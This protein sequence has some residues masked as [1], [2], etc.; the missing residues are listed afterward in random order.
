[1]IRIQPSAGFTLI[2][3]LVAMAIFAIG[4]GLVVLG[5]GQLADRDMEGEAAKITAW[6][7]SLSDRAVLEG[8]I[9]GFRVVENQLQAVSWYDHQWLVVEHEG[10]LS[11]PANIHFELATD[12]P[13]KGFIAQVDSPQTMAAGASTGLTSSDANVLLPEDDLIE[14][15]MVFMPSGEPMSEGEIYLQRSSGDRLRQYWTI[16]GTIAYETEAEI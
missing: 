9:Y 2:E 14:P 6:M 15:L 10:Q 1:M 16:D 8:S 12:Q 11:L 13:Q 3:V 7:E 4:L 5:F